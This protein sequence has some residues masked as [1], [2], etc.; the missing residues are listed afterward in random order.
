[1]Q[2]QPIMEI[3]NIDQHQLEK[4][5]QELLQLK[6]EHQQKLQRKNL[7]IHELQEELH[8]VK[9]IEGLQ[10]EKLQL[11]MKQLKEELDKKLQLKENQIKELQHEMKQLKLNIQSK[12]EHQL[13]Q[14]QADLV[15]TKLSKTPPRFPQ[16][17]P[18]A[19]SHKMVIIGEV[20]SGRTSFAQLLLNYS[21]QFHSTDFTLDLVKSF[22]D[23]HTK[24]P[25][26][27]SHIVTMPKS[28]TATFGDFV[29]DIILP[30]GCDDSIDYKNTANIIAILKKELYINCVCL[31][32]NGMQVRLTIAM[33]DVITQI[34]SILPPSVLRN[35]IVVYTFTRDR[36]SLKFEP[37]L[38]QEEFQLSI[39]AKHQ[40][41][42]DNSYSRYESYRKST[43]K[44][45]PNPK[46]QKMLRRDF[47]DCNEILYDIFEVIKSF[48]PARTLKFGEFQEAVDNIKVCF[49]KLKVHYKNK[50]EIKKLIED[51]GSYESHVKEVTYTET[52]TKDSEKKNLTC[53]VCHRN[54]HLPCDCWFTFR[55]CSQI[56]SGKCTH[57]SHS[58]S[59]HTVSKI[60]YD[61]V[62]KTISL[63][64]QDRTA[65]RKKLEE[66]LSVY[67][68]D[69][70][71]ETRVLE[72]QL[73]EFQG[74]G[75]NFIFSK[76]AIKQINQLIEELQ[77]ILPNFE[78][79]EKMLRILND[80]KEVMADP[81][82]AKNQE[83]TARWACG[84]LGLD[85]KNQNEAELN[86]FF[87]Q[88]AQQ[89]HPDSTG[90]DST[91]SAFKHAKGYVMR[92][93]LV[94]R[95]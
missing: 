18:Q 31:I 28:Y 75:S 71:K 15:Y 65:R 80:T 21:K 68:N 55:A 54:C 39:P 6:E 38:L 91:T 52:V 37:K 78:H 93:F 32:I 43:D 74:V 70:A 84:I 20:G 33:K 47:E 4:L 59:D 87:R 77:A 35:I 7:Q 45:D 9:L 36:F 29:L 90:D 10:K 76:N 50:D 3:H 86:K 60:Y 88:Q 23:H 69:I 81:T 53:S 62:S 92:K 17:T 30:P 64:D 51:V 82:T 41:M 67:N 34:V 1:M 57:C 5:Q 94:N 8:S 26:V 13:F 12:K 2:E 66:K 25:C 85:P 46:E 79:K 49:S 73:K 44:K 40:F 16:A 19:S 48:K 58:Y 56:Q 27:N 61:N 95:N 83:I 11:E 42:L 72:S 14:I 22:I 89:V 24:Q 63:P